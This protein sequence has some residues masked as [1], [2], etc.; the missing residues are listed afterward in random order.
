[1]KKSELKTLIKEEIKKVLNE[2]KVTI[3]PLL[4][5]KLKVAIK[6]RIRYPEDEDVHDELQMLLTQI[7]QKAGMEDAEELAAGNMEDEVTMTGPVSAVVS[8][9]KDTMEDEMGSGMSGGSSSKAAV[10]IFPSW[11][12]GSSKSSHIA[13]DK[14]ATGSIIR[15]NMGRPAH[16]SY[17]YP[18]SP[19]EVLQILTK[20]NAVVK[21]GSEWFEPNDGLIDNV[22]E[23]NTKF[24][25]ITNMNKQEL[26]NLIKEEIRNVLNESSIRDIMPVV[27]QFVEAAKKKYKHNLYDVR[28]HK[29][30][31]GNFAVNAYVKTEKWDLPDKYWSNKFT[32]NFGNAVPGIEIRFSTIPTTVRGSSDIT[33]GK[34]VLKF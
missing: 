33:L 8:L 5:N 21:K 34:S 12:T 19:M 31:S 23:S 28:V 32:K 30:L 22:L 9:I 17:S 24:K 29:T 15:D 26:N 14:T 1:M 13:I 11:M 25:E 4:I 27:T 16:W 3:D 10:M 7:Y 18:G 2:A 20:A 6:D